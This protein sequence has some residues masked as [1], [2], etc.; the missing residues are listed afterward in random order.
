[1]VKTEVVE[2]SVEAFQAS[3]V[4]G[5]SGA[6]STEG[7]T[8]ATA[9]RNAD[10]ED[11]KGDILDGAGGNVPEN[12]L[13]NATLGSPKH[14]RKSLLSHF[15]PTVKNLIIRMHGKMVCLLYCQKLNNGE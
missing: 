4:S 2:E 14:V 8:A 10:A 6:E 12:E 15:F 13:W 5:I 3:P 7:Q 1:M 9:K 11:R